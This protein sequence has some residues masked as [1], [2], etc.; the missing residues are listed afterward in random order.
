MSWT[1]FFRRRHWD[2]E[3]T[4]EI[5]S[6]LQIETDENMARGMPAQD[7]RHAAHRKL[8][9]PA[10]IREEIHQMNTLGLLETFWQDLRYGTRLLRLSPGFAF[11]AIVSLALGIGANTAIFHLVNAVLLRALP[12]K[13]SRDLAEIRIADMNAARG[14]FNNWNAAFTNSLWERI[15]H[16]RKPFDGMFAWASDSFNLAP[17]GQTRPA[18]ALWVSG[19]FF[20]VLGVQPM[21]GRVLSAPDDHRG[22]GTP[23]AVISHAFWQREFGGAASAVGSKL[24]LDGHPVEVIGV[25]PAGFFGL[26]IGRQFDIAVPICSEAVL[27]AY[28]ALDDGTMWWLTVMGR[29]RPG[30][31]IERAGAWLNTVSP[32]IFEATLPKNYPPESRPS[33]LAFRLAAYPAETGISPLRATYSNPLYLLLAIAGVVLLIA[34]ANLA[35][36]MLARAST[37]EREI[38]V[39]LALGASRGRLVRQL[40]A[41]SLMIAMLGAVLGAFLA[42]SLSQFLVSFLSTEGN[43][44]FVDLSTDW[45]VLSFTTGLAALTCALFGLMPAL[46]G[47][48]TAPG[49]ALK[50]AG[51]GMTADRE[52]FGI[53]RALVASQVALSLVL[54]VN[55]LLFSRSLRNLT[56]VDPGFRQDGVLIADMDLV[57]LNIP[58]ARWHEFERD[59]IDRIRAVPGVE[60]AAAVRFIPLGGAG[61]SNKVW[62]GPGEEIDSNINWIGPG[63]FRTLGIPLLAGRDFDPHDTQQ[64]PRVAIVS[65]AFARRPGIGPNPV[66]RT[67]RRE[68]TPYDPETVFEIVGL[69]K[70]TK[71]RDLR[72]DFPPIAYLATAQ[73]KF[74]QD[75]IAIRSRV[76]VAPAIKST[77]RDFAPRLAFNFRV[78]RTQIRESLLRERL[79]A[80]LSAFFGALAGLLATMGLYGVISYMVARRR[81][82]IGIR[83]ALGAD[84]KDVLGMILRDAGKLL[85]AGLTIGSA[86]AVVAA[87]TAGSLL[88]GLKPWDPSLSPWPLCFWR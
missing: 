45:R 17:A 69:A 13:N 79:M 85:A 8:G 11:V 54:L 77:I 27:R 12:V 86:L 41:E 63:Y 44:L 65:E 73:E 62:A 71:Y 42:Q 38:A 57:S 28:S 50:S 36:L 56:R 37:R 1:R 61:T 83:I 58:V 3:R 26:E 2:H 29:L 46:Q 67:F 43:P 33:Y 84:R 75:Q 14:S 47:A 21:L 78:L 4:R 35:S 81:N 82:E 64:S 6:Y 59:L 24:T 10:L 74:P 72:E 55:A 66:G 40:L 31:S 16:S 34:C 7:A 9:N 76:S 53:R 30:W 22:C 87:R 5:Q 20:R 15:R 39:R 49:A 52:R 48:R 25:T 32:G 51:R 19:D 70:D 88:F 80:A 18:R 60:S 68:A 23:G